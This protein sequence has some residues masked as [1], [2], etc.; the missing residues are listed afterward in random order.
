MNSFLSLFD[1]PF[2][3]SP[4]G[5]TLVSAVAVLGGFFLLWLVLLRWSAKAKRH[6]QSLIVLA[7]NAS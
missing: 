4:L 6:I 7:Q 5:A 3:D 2:G 1:N